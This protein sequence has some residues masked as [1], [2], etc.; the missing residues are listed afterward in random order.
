M[1]DSG[2][3]ITQLAKQTVVSIYV[4]AEEAQHQ[5][6]RDALLVHARKSSSRPEIKNMIA[7]AQSEYGMVIHTK[8][9]DSDPWLLNCQNGTV[10]LKTGQ[11]LPHQPDHFI[12]K[13]APVTYDQDAT[14]PVFDQFIQKITKGEQEK[15]FF[16]QRSFGYAFT[17]STR[18]E[19]LFILYGR[20]ANGKSTLIEMFRELIGDYALNNPSDSFLSGKSGMIRS[21]IARMDGSRFVSAVEVGI[22]SRLNESL[23]KSL[24]GRDKVT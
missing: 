14:C 18:E 6:D 19:C 24:T 17:G 13:M 7:L 4:E 12:T 15:I 16:I 11:L 1:K 2:E 3:R 10:D 8:E 23:V 20:G 22:G 9:L 21:D 5:N